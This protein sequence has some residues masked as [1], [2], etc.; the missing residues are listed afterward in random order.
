MNNFTNRQGTN[1]NK[2]VFYVDTVETD[3]NDQ[4]TKIKGVIERDDDPTSVGTPLEANQFNQ[5]VRN[6]VENTMDYAINDKSSAFF[7]DLQA[8][9]KEIL[10]EHTGYSLQKA[11]K[12]ISYTEALNNQISTVITDEDVVVKKIS[13]DENNFNISITT[14]YNTSNSTYVTKITH[15]ANSASAVEGNSYE[16]VY[17][18]KSKSTNET[19]KKF[20][21]TLYYAQQPAAAED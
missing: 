17:L 20:I 1:L 21:V 9:I 3:A 8:R 5:I 10:V 2:K 18:I 12:N 15:K 4:I 7:I 13:C 6:L 14:N 16:F 19:I 11:Y